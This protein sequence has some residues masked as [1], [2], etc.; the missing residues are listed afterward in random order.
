[1]G[2]IYFIAMLLSFLILLAYGLWSESSL[3]NFLFY[4]I[5][6]LPFFGHVTMSYI[7]GNKLTNRIIRV[8]DFI[9]KGI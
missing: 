1:M 7:E 9:E 3:E 6:M 4:V 5:F 2:K 8:K